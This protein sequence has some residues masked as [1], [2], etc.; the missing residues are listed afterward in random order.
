MVRVLYITLTARLFL[1]QPFSFLGDPGGTQHS[2]RNRRDRLEEP[3]KEPCCSVILNTIWL[4][5]PKSSSFQHSILATGSSPTP[6]P[7]RIPTAAYGDDKTK[8]PSGDFPRPQS[9]HWSVILTPGPEPTKDADPPRA[10][11][12]LPFLW[13][14]PRRLGLRAQENGTQSQRVLADRGGLRRGENQGKQ[15]ESMETGLQPLEN[16]NYSNLHYFKVSY[17]QGVAV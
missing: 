12:T 17:S 7:H 14:S 5:S 15:V 8:A 9:Q 3:N 10:P 4:I 6:A 2:A 1:N 16:S 11:Q 13:G